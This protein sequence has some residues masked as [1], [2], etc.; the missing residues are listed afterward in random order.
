MA[1]GF[2]LDGPCVA[3]FMDLGSELAQGTMEGEYGG[4]EFLTLQPCG[5]DK[6]G[7]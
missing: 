4:A 5:R 3:G 2:R 7:V 6:D 1:H